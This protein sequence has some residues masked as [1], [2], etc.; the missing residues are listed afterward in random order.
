MTT[1]MIE[2]T[3]VVTEAEEPVVT[4][5]E[6]AAA[7]L[8]TILQEKNLPNHGLRVFVAGGGCS[9]LQYGMAFEAEQRDTDTVAEIHGVKLYVDPIS[10][11]YLQGSSID[12]TDDLMGGGFRIN[13]PNAVS[14]CGCGSSVCTKNSGEGSAAGCGWN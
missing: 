1:T 2:P 6:G 10:L 9:G 12:Y 3:P 7:K 14:T 4:L 11:E 5:S 8:Q 13:N